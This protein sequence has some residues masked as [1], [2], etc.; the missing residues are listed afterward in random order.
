MTPAQRQA[1]I[2]TLLDPGLV[3]VPELATP[4][5]RRKLWHNV[6]T[7][8]EARNYVRLA[9]KLAREWRTR[10]ALAIVA[11]LAGE[12]VTMGMVRHALWRDVDRDR[13]IWTVRLADGYPGRK[14]K[15]GRA[16]TRPVSLRP[17]TIKL[18]KK[19][20]DERDGLNRLLCLVQ[21]MDTAH[22]PLHKQRSELGLPP[23]PR[24]PLERYLVFPHDFDKPRKPLAEHAFRYL[25]DKLGY[26]FAPYDLI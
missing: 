11:Q 2:A 3:L 25:L 7:P 18:L 17:A 22:W 8:Q 15:A 4:N 10:I 9:P 16:M 14:S 6:S 13:R 12:G 20:R 23:L 21:P 19:A 24:P 5:K 26:P 1:V